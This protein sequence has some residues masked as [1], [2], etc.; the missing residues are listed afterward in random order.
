MN[1]NQP[2]RVMAFVASVCLF[3]TVITMPPGHHGEFEWVSMIKGLLPFLESKTGLPFMD[4]AWPICIGFFLVFCVLMFLAL[5]FVKAEK[6]E[7][8]EEKDSDFADLLTTRVVTELSKD[9]LL[10]ADTSKG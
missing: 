7:L 3:L 5:I 1:N 6:L 8:E 10:K 4:Y 2:S 9:G